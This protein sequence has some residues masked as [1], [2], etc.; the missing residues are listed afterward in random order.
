MCEACRQGEMGQ[1]ELS[2]VRRIHDSAVWISDSNW[3]QGRA[4]VDDVGGNGAEVGRA[5]TVGNCKGIRR[6]K[7]GGTYRNRDRGKTSLTKIIR[8]VRRNGRLMGL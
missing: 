3:F 7:F 1:I 4:F 6:I 2:F 5:A 8:I